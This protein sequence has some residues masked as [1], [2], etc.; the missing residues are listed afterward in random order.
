[1]GQDKLSNG[2]GL[3]LAIVRKLA[4]ANAGSVD[5]ETREGETSFVVTFEN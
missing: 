3:G 1:M 4:E 2:A 5:F